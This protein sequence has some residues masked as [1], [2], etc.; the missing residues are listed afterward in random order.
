MGNLKQFIKSRFPSA[1]IFKK[2]SL[3]LIN[4]VLYFI[5]LGFFRITLVIPFILCKIRQSFKTLPQGRKSMLFVLDDERLYRDRDGSGRYAYLIM[6]SFSESGYNIYF[7]KKVSLLRFFQF[8]IRGRAIYSI[9]NLKFITRLPDN[10]EDMNLAFDSVRE[11]ILRRKW[12]KI[13]YVNVLKPTFCKV[14]EVISIPYFLHASMYQYNVISSLEGCRENQRKMRIFFGGNTL[15]S[16]YDFQS[17]KNI[18]NQLNRH[19]AL[20]AVLGAGD[21]R[22]KVVE[23]KERFYKLLNG[24]N[25]IN[26]FY[27]YQTDKLPPIVNKDWLNIVSKSDFFLCFSGTDLPMCHNAIESLAVG[28]I[29]IISYPDWF[30]PPLEHRKNAILYSGKEDLIN[31]INEVFEMSSDEIEAMRKNAIMYYENNLSRVSF[32]DRFEASTAKVNTIM[33]HPRLICNERENEEGRHIL[34]AMATHLEYI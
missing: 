3:T 15:R 11:D 26:E 30:F 23:N 18:Y 28:T 17:I 27:I 25:Y 32:M 4:S 10:S 24:D 12:K 22:I 7:Y 33:L 14:G 13:T 20:S 9:K 21:K 6:N 5:K 31:K 1:I 29:P 8:G 19:E 16:G 34:K 2:R